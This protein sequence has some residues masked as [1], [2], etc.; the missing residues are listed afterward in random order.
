M[1][2]MG[3]NIFQPVNTKQGYKDRTN[4][5]HETKLEYLDKQQAH[6]AKIQ[7]EKTAKRKNQQNNTA[8][9]TRNNEIY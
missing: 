5:Q 9:G 4:Q 8:K 7:R 6:F 1:A 3:F 2:N